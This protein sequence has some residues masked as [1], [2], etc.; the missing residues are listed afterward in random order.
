MKLFLL[1]LVGTISGV[2]KVLYNLFK[3]VDGTLRKTAHPKLR[4][5]APMGRTYIFYLPGGPVHLGDTF[6]GD[7]Y[8]AVHKLGY[9][10]FSTVSSKTENEGDMQV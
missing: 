8:A 1:M 9:G 2:L 3:T 10:Q 6:R 4:K 5:R 7:T